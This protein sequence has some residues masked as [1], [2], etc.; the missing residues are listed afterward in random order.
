MS[1]KITKPRIL[2]IIVCASVLFNFL[3]PIFNLVRYAS[4]ALVEYN[5]TPCISASG[6]G[7]LGNRLFKHVE[8][9]RSTLETGV[10]IH[11][12]L[13]SILFLVILF[14]LIKGK[15]N[16]IYEIISVSLGAALSLIYTIFGI[17]GA[18]QVD[19]LT[20]NLYSV[21]TFAYIPLII[22]CVLGIAYFIIYNFIDNDFTLSIG[23]SQ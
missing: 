16:K 17:Y 6:Y 5:N 10:I 3:T 13:S 22:S 7:L 15:R 11:I 9:V 23:K 8:M 1:V 2:V 19:R 20:H 4:D 18:S 12:V 14:Y 21:A